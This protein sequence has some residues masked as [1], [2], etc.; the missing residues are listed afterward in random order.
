MTKT[1]SV[2]IL[3]RDLAMDSQKLSSDTG[4]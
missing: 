1:S 2:F 3:M 4:N